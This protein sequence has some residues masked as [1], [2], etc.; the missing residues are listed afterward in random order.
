MKQQLDNQKFTQKLMTTV[1]HC[2]K[3]YDVS[4]EKK[5]LAHCR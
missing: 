1:L 3:N 2:K 4:R 5:H